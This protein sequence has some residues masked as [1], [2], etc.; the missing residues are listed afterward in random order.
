MENVNYAIQ[1]YQQA[2]STIQPEGLVCKL[3]Q[4]IYTYYITQV[5]I[6]GPKGTV[7][8]YVGTIGPNGLVDSTVIGDSNTAGYSTPIRIPPGQEVFVVWIGI[9]S[10]SA[11]AA[12]TCQTGKV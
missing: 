2:F 11:V 10:G 7:G 4:S 6:T 12:F 8:I 5:N 9:T 1:P 3:P